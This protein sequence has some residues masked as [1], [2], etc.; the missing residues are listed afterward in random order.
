MDKICAGLGFPVVMKVVGPLHKTD[1]GGVVLDVSSVEA[2]RDT[3]RRLMSI[4]EA[5]GVLV[6]PMIEGTELIVGAAREEGFGTLVMFGLG[7]VFTEVLRDVKFALAPL[8]I[9]ESERI[10]DSIRGRRLLDGVRGG[11]GV[12]VGA[13]ADIISRVGLLVSD[14]PEIVELDLNPIKGYGSELYAVDARIIVDGA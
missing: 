4:D 9:E 11:R 13:V 3:W 5:T 10:V 6:Q 8:G 2:A 7:G 14:F 12:D 1:V